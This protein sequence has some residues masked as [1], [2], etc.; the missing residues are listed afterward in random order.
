[1]KK[2]KNFPI[3]SSFIELIK[4]QEG[5]TFI[6]Q[7]II[8]NPE[9]DRMRNLFK[10]ELKGGYY[11][12][13][14]KVTNTL[15]IGRAVNFWV[16][17]SSYYNENELTKRDMV[18][19]RSMLKHGPENHILVISEYFGSSDDCRGSVLFRTNEMDAIN[20]CKPTYGRHKL[21][22][23]IADRAS[24]IRTANTKVHPLIQATNKLVLSDRGKLIAK[25]PG[26]S[27]PLHF[28]SI[29]AKFSFFIGQIDGRGSFFIMKTMFAGQ[30]YNVFYV[31]I[32][33]ND[34][35][36]DLMDLIFLITGIR[37]IQGKGGKKNLKS[38]Y[39]RS[40]ITLNIQPI[41][42]SYPKKG[43][44]KAKSFEEFRHVILSD[45]V[46]YSDNLE[47]VS[48]SGV[49]NSHES[50]D[51]DAWV[52]GFLT[53]TGGFAHGT[54]TFSVT[55]TDRGVLELLLQYFNINKTIELGRTS[56][57]IR[58]KSVPHMMKVINKF[59]INPVKFTGPKLEEYN[60]FQDSIEV[61]PRFK[62][63]FPRL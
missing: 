44:D 61:D 7:L 20:W 25:Q 33:I 21:N 51:M 39:D 22:T 18:I 38:I 13:Y 4:F 53:V 49:K 11:Q 41:I 32:A 57:V 19:Y 24:G 31:R 59:E 28:D 34:Q 60:R 12:W 16:R 17:L 42:A 2:N 50:I 54:N 40:L 15:Y 30:D 46:Y 9:R 43:R 6:P 48:S 62:G 3:S 35:G 45:N 14:N 10:G 55:F 8:L 52:I 1:M 29:D 23:D 26:Y 58:I 36:P 27:N 37:F 47:G 63:K 5:S 56:F